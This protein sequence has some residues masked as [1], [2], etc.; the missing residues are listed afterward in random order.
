MFDFTARDDPQRP[1]TTR[2]NPLL[3]AT[4][5]HGSLGYL[6]YLLTVR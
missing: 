4:V 2:Y 5:R 6:G 3:P 1:A